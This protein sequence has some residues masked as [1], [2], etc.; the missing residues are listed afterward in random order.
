LVEVSGWLLGNS[1]TFITKDIRNAASIAA[2]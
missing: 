1:A 2:A